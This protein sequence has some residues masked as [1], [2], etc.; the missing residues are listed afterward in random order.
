MINCLMF[1]TFAELAEQNRELAN[2]NR[3]QIR[4]S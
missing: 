1:Q 2:Q 4:V 3:Q